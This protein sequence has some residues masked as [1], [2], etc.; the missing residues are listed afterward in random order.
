M[1]LS[2]LKHATNRYTMQCIY[3]HRHQFR[4]LKSLEYDLHP[5]GTDLKNLGAKN[6]LMPSTPG[7]RVITTVGEGTTF[8][9][10]F[11]NKWLIFD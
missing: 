1:S 10:G 2:L 3:F 5:K 7:K 8:N 4:T 11:L 6:I 9:E